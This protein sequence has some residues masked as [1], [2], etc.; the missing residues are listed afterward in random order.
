MKIHM[1]RK[2]SKLQ[3]LTFGLKLV[4]VIETVAFVGSYLLWRKMNKDRGMA[5]KFSS[6]RYVTKTINFALQKLL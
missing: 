3:S 6:F 1:N 2:I 5:Y 4:V